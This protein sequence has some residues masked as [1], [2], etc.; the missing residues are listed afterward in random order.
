M[1]ADRPKRLGGRVKADPVVKEIMNFIN[2]ESIEQFHLIFR[3]Y[4]GHKGFG[5]WFRGQ[6]DSNWELIPKAGRKEYFLPKNRDIGRFND[7]AK[8]AIA[9]SSLPPNRLECLAV[10]QHHGL[11]TRLL[12]WSQNPLVAAYFAVTEKPDLDGAIY[13]LEPINSFVS[14]ESSLEDIAE[15]DG[16]ICYIPRSISPRVL[17]QKG[18]FT[19]HCPP[20]KDVEICESQYSK[21]HLNLMK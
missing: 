8:Q 17:N 11:A 12:D 19:I 1:D 6:A 13:I 21:E 2:L 14:S 10:A 16:V 7:W 4:R 3:A 9:Y 15:H 18:M 20:D 5:H